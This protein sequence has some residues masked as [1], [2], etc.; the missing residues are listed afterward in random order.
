[1][2][3]L[4]GTVAALVGAIMRAWSRPGAP[5][6]NVPCR[7]VD[8]TGE[9]LAYRAVME[10]MDALRSLGFIHY[11][12]PF[13]DRTNGVGRQTRIWP[14]RKL[15]ALA[16]DCGITAATIKRHFGRSKES[17]ERAVA[18]EVP[19]LIVLQGLS[20]RSGVKDARAL[21]FDPE[22][23]EAAAIRA[24]VTAQN[25]LAAATRIGGCRPPQWCRKFKLDWSLH[26]RWYVPGADS[27]QGMSAEERLEITIAGEPVVEIDI[28]ASL[29]SLL[30]GVL[31]LPLPA[32]DLYSIPR[33][34]RD[35]VK[36]WINATLGKGSPVVRWSKQTLA[37][38]PAVADHDARAVGALVM[39]RYPFLAN[40][41]VVVERRVIHGEPRR[42][43]HHMLTGI[44]AA[45]L[46]MTIAGL[47]ERGILGLPMHDGLIVPA[48][49]EEIAC[50]LLR[51]A[52]E[53]IAGVTLRLDVDGKT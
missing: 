26:G 6:V 32:D 52:G 5:P 7:P 47:R 30:H 50:R 38:H 48:S 18:P 42:I 11:A 23:P 3:M 51:E 40:P 39:A 1:M 45:V 43:L 17:M 15:L 41:W 14:T 12:R 8:Y 22:A 31:G 37:D 36:A 16:T 27:Y 20:S 28:K 19:A 34:P 33:V 4:E 29:I 44:E 10:T 35:G 2:A 13:L 9:A 46:T 24:D 25:D 21:P 49:A 53:Q